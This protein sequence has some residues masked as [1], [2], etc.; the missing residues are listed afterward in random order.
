[1]KNAFFVDTIAVGLTLQMNHA[2]SVD[3]TQVGL[4]MKRDGG[5]KEHGHS[6]DRS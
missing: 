1:M 5:T 6:I 2:E 3:L 4:A